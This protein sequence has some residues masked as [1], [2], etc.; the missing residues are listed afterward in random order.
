MT[1]TNAD[2]L[3]KNIQGTGFDFDLVAHN[4]RGRL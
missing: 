2:G 4:R 1:P 3:G